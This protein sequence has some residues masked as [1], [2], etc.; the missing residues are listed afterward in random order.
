MEY[1]NKKITLL[2]AGKSKI[3]SLN[4]NYSLPISTKAK[5]YQSYQNEVIQL[6]ENSNQDIDSN[7]IE[8][9]IENL[10]SA[11]HYLLNIKID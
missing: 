9:S 4:Q 11:L 6:I 2:S 8:H 3:I 5:N 7:N 1:F 10:E